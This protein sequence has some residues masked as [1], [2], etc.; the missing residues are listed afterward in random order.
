MRADRYAELGSH[1]QHREH[2]VHAAK[3]ASIDL[4]EVDRIGLEELLEHD[5][6][7]AMLAGCDPDAE[8]AHGLGHLSVTE[9]VI[10]AQRLFDPPRLVFGKTLHVRD[11]LVHLPDLVGVHHQYA[12]PADLLSQ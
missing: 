2:F 10:W 11:R 12:I 7:L 5:T 4:A 8:G 6:V 1:Q 9:H 3:P